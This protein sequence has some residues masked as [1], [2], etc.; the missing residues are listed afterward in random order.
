[1]PKKLI[2]ENWQPTPSTL[3]WCHAN[4]YDAELH[5]EFFRDYC[6]STEAKYAS[7]DAAF[8]NC[9]RSDWGNVRKN[10]TQKTAVAWWTSDEATIEYGNK[11]GLPPRRGESIFDYRARLRGAT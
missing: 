8:R 1:M 5:L 11:R 4:K 2:P 7:F 10:A 9:C 3:A 6:E